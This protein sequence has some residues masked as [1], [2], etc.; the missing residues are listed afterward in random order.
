MLNKLKNLENFDETLGP[1][2][3][4]EYS[5]MPDKFEFSSVDKCLIYMLIASVKT[6]LKVSDASYYKYDYNITLPPNTKYFVP[7]KFDSSKTNDSIETNDSKVLQESQ[8]QSKGDGFKSRTHELLKTLIATADK[9][10]PREKEG[11]R[12]DSNV[13]SLA[14]YIRLVGGRLTYDSI[15]RNLPLA[16]PSLSSVNRY[17][18]RTN[19]KMHEGVLR[20]T[21]LSNYLDQ[22]SLPR[23]I[24]LSED[25]TRIT[26]TVQYHSKSNEILG[27]VLPTNSITGMPVPHSYPAKDLKQICEYFQNK[28]PVANFVNVIMAQPMAHA[29]AF[30]LLLFGSNSKYTAENV[31]ARWHFITTELKRA[32]IDVVTISSDSDA[33]YNSAMRK[34]SM[35]GNKS[36]LFKDVD[37]FQMGSEHGPFYVQ[38][39]I[40][41]A[42]KLRNRFLTTGKSPNRFPFGPKLYIRVAHLNLLLKNYSK[43]QHSLTA[44]VLNPLDRQNFQSVLRICDDMVIKLLEEKVPGSEGTAKFLQMSK[45]IIDSYSNVHLSPRERIRKVWEP[46]FVLRIWREYISSKNKLSLEK[47]FLTHN[48]YICIEIIAHSIVLIMLHLQKINKPELF[49]PFLYESQACESTF[50]QIRSMSTVYCTVTNC[51]V[52]EMIDRINRIELQSEIATSTDFIFPRIK[53]NFQFQDVKNDEMLMK[54]QIIDEIESCK[55]DAIQYAIKIGILK[56]NGT[57]KISLP[58]KVAPLLLKV[59]LE[60]SE[61]DPAQSEDDWEDE[62]VF[63]EINESSINCKPKFYNFVPFKSIKLKNFA[64]EFNNLEIPEHSEYIEVYRQGERRKIIKKSSLVWLL[65]QEAPKLS[66]DRLQRV[67]TRYSTRKQNAKTN[68]KI[69]RKASNC[70]ILHKKIKKL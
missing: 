47:N 9:N 67:K 63:Q 12:F 48:C 42:T 30:C 49:F 26:G 43:D 27:L 7:S 18:M 13:K 14:T 70:K 59:N 1:I 29:P 16:L 6:T 24:A 15:H 3:Y 62:D 17:I 34:L 50:R 35:L 5:T 36:I 46:V 38:D 33:K 22:R 39:I 57:K 61:D 55:R 65:R 69:Y 4:G 21:E 64:G 11:Y 66:S 54:D 60:E 25:A 45:N 8:E 28:I 10:L 53:R 68:L 20:I 31:A 44:N 40:H 51:S 32:K 2:F 37:W 19:R 52:K 58:C 56:K 23:I 41:I